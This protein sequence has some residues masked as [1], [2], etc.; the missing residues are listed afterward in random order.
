[1]LLGRGGGGVID[2]STLELNLT[3]RIQ[4]HA[5]GNV[6]FLDND[7]KNAKLKLRVISRNYY[8]SLKYI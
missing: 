4:K 8:I 7:W 1:M 2:G 5:F 3:L 6:F